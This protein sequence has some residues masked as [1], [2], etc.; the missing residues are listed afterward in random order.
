M[1]NKIWVTI[2]V[3]IL[4]LI[5]MGLGVLAVF[6]FE[7]ADPRDP[8]ESNTLEGEASGTDMVVG[9]EPDYLFEHVTGGT[10]VD[11]DEGCEVFL[12][13][14]LLPYLERLEN[15]VP[16][17]DE[18]GNYYLNADGKIVYD[19][20]TEKHVEGVLDNLITLIN[21]FAGE[22]Y[23]MEASHQIQRFYVQYYDRFHDTSFDDLV[24]GLAMCFPKGGADAETLAETVLEVFGIAGGDDFASVFKTLE[25]AE[26]RVDFSNVKPQEVEL[27]ADDEALCIYDDV[28]N[29][30]DSGYERNLESW[31]H[32]VISVC[33]E[34]SLDDERIQVA[35]LVYVGSLAD[36]AYRADWDDT[37]IRCLSVENWTFD[38]LKLAVET[39]FGVSLDGNVP[40]QYHFEMKNMEVDH[41]K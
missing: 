34:A 41:E 21:H 16:A 39:E 18:D 30:E 38:D 10:V 24:A 20:S 11:F 26:I 13:M 19:T 15:G 7:T 29:P 22:E 4:L 17:T 33:K 35:Q 8:A 9:T 36:A 1:K 14:S 32:N 23:S 40:V 6:R 3:A 37:L 27:S 25:V 31:L 5:A 28:K 12:D 2:A